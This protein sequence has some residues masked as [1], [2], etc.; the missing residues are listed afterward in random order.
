MTDPRLTELIQGEID[1]ELD[2]QQRAELARRL[3][4]D[5]Q[6][7][8]ERDELRRVCAELD[9]IPQVQP[10]SALRDNVLAALPQGQRT[11][12][13][14]ILTR[15]MWVSAHRWR[16][17]AMLAVVLAA[18]AIVFQTVRGP[19]P[20]GTE[21]AG[22]MATGVLDKAQLDGPVSG[23][24]ALYRDA[25]GL[26]LRFD[27]AASGPIQVVIR[28]DGQTL[29][30]D[31]TTESDSAG[32]RR[33]IPLTGITAHGQSLGLTFLLAG[34]PAGSAQLRLPEAP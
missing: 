1:G 3:L 25:A 30:L 20:A 9:A 22:T 24:V 23:T 31:G 28:S 11:I 16:Y 27:L 8:G 21:A 14:R 4:A 5:P 7:R 15:D 17:A 26:G 19:G 33:T 13:P 12:R 2:V 32:L 6:A 29:R 18:G 34:R 10:P